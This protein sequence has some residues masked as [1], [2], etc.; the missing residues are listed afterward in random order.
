MGGLVTLLPFTYTMFLIGSFSLIAVPFLTGYYS[1][2]LIILIGYSQYLVSGNFGF[3]LT[4]V[5]AVLTAIY[6]SRLL[7]L[8]FFG[9]PNGN[10]NTY[11]SIHEASLIMAIPL[12]ILAIFS[13][14]FGFFARDLFVGIG[15]DFFGSSLFTHPNYSILVDTELGL[16]TNLKLLPLFGTILGIVS[17]ILVYFLFPILLVNLTNNTL[18][19]IIYRYLN[20]AHYFDN[21]YTN[22]ISKPLLNFGYITNKVLDKGVFELL[23]PYGFT[24]LFMTASN[25]I[26]SLDSGHIS[27]FAI[28]II[29]GVFLFI[30]SILT[31]SNPKYLILVLVTMLFL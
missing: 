26:M 7:Y 5:S 17:V 12:V 29:L 1:K 9:Y 3:W 11:N 16:S 14:F 2:E 22:F 21:L 20:Q 10:R 24:S 4:T 6:S 19:R 27:H 13:M 28:F 15:S 30:S 31:I 23:G 25:R 8:T 18:V